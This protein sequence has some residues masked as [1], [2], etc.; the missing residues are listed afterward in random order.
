MDATA[1]LQLLTIS[2]AAGAFF[3]VLKWLADGKFHTHSEVQGLR[4]DKK[5][6]LA[7]NKDQ[8][9]ALR[10]SNVL[11]E[12][13]LDT[14][15]VLRQRLGD[16]MPISDREYAKAAVERKRKQRETDLQADQ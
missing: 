12:R 3:L 14:I 15:S 5:A 4:D 9:E 16:P 11:H 2:G 1:I 7:V 10:A 8:A 13:A 6:L